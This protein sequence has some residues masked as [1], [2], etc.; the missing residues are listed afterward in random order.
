MSRL[1]FSGEWFLITC[2]KKLI[3]IHTKESSEPFVFDCCC[4]EKRPK[5][6]KVVNGS[7]GD[8][9]EDPGSDSILAFA[10]SSSGKLM[11]LT[12]DTKRLVLFHCE[13]S[14]HCVSISE[15]ICGQTMKD[16]QQQR[17]RGNGGHVDHSQ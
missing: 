3:A 16:D 5:S 9:L 6:A 2:G 14:W 8:A 4:A 7:D 15:N 17:T 13:P 10:V 12:D 1:G 11:A